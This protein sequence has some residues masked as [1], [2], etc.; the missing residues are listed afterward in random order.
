MIIRKATDERAAEPAQSPDAAIGAQ[1]K[2][3]LAIAL[4]AI[5]LF[6]FTASAVLPHLV[7]AWNGEAATPDLALT[8]ALL[9]NVAL[10]LMGWKR[11]QILSSELR[12]RRLSEEEMRRLADID[13]LTACLNRRSFTAAAGAAIAAS[14]ND[15][16]ALAALVIDLDNFK[17]V[18][19]L[20]G[21]ATGDA[22]LRTTAL[23]INDLLPGDSLLA[24]LGGDEFVM[25][26]PGQTLETAE[27]IGRW[28]ID[29]LSEPIRF[30]DGACARIGASAGAAR[31]SRGQSADEVLLV[32][33]HA[34]YAA[35]AG[36]KGQVVMAPDL[37]DGLAEAG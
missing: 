34:L 24:R 12:Q 16:T 6:V 17:Q 4:A 5:V 18:N 9:L 26:L 31:A 21:H 20:N 15:K 35:K 10:I 29:A 3:A 14:S 13:H 8:N 19:D 2:L 28:A 32:A 23:R 30:D 33:D 37:P 27:T 11:Y 36:G 1:D 22:V 25:L 7:Q